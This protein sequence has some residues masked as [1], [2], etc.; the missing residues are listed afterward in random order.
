HSGFRSLHM[1]RHLNATDTLGDTYRMR[2]VSAFVMDPV[3]VGTSTLLDFWHIISVCDDKC[4]NA[5]PGG[6]FAGGQVPLSLQNP[7]NGIWG[8]GAADQPGEERLQLRGAERRRHLSVRPQRRPI[9]AARSDDVHGA[10]G[11]VVGSW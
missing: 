11:N 4:S 5:G 8:E 3:N 1:G 7:G 10:E 6:T 9:T 2:Q